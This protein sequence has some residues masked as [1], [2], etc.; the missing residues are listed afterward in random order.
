MQ[1][2]LLSLGDYYGKEVQKVAHKL[3]EEH[4]IDI[5]GSDIHNLNQLQELK[6]LKVSEKT[7]RK[8]LPII[9]HTI[10]TFY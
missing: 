7:L 5:V 3:L 6:E 2:N 1:M 4:L 9:G 10:E 8:L